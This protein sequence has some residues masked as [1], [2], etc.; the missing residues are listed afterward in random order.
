[1]IDLITVSVCLG[2]ACHLKGAHGVLDAFLALIEKHQAQA[3]VQMSGNFCQGRCTEGVVVQIGDLLLT[4]VS[5]DQV[6]Q[7]FTKYVLNGELA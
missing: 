4:N 7:L 5:K 3:Q 1:M 6:H 2:S